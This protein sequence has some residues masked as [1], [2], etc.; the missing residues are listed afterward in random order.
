MFFGLRLH[1][2]G[3]KNTV[4][5][6]L[7]FLKLISFIILQLSAAYYFCTQENLGM[8]VTRLRY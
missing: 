8:L 1:F 3:L 4:V 2:S 7:G 5:R 6:I